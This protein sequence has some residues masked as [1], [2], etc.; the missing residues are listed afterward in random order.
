MQKAEVCKLVE[1]ILL[2]LLAC[3]GSSYA[4]DNATVSGIVRDMT[5]GSVAHAEVSLR[6]AQQAIV[7]AAKTD[8]QGR[9]K[10]SD[11]HE[12][13]YLLVIKSLGFAERCMGLNVRQ[14]NVENIEVT[15]ELQPLS[16]QVT[17]TANQGLVEDTETVTQQVNVIGERAI[18]E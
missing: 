2:L 18:D 6:D 8:A 14:S 13:R 3:T 7:G 17:V 15:L 16:D 10:F 12:G 11:V 1:V 9:F 5:G 4:R